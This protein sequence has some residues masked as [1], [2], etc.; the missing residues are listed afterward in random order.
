MRQSQERLHRIATE[1]TVEELRATPG[2]RFV[3][4][5]EVIQ[6]APDRK[7]LLAHVV[8]LIG[9]MGASGGE[10]FAFA[11]TLTNGDVVRMR[12]GMETEF[13]GDSSPVLASCVAQL[14]A[15]PPADTPA[16]TSG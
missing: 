15:H 4:Y 6:C 13:L 3:P 1:S 8:T 9:G 5:H 12:W 2:S 14:N 10:A 7:S 16:N 11:L